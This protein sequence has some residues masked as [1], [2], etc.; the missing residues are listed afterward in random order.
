MTVTRLL[1]ALACTVA[2]LGGSPAAAQ[3]QA[4]GLWLL[5]HDDSVTAQ[6]SRVPAGFQ[7]FHL[8]RAGDDGDFQRITEVPVRP[9]R[10]PNR[11]LVLLGED[12]PVLQDRTRSATEPEL[13]RRLQSNPVVASLYSYL[14]PS[15][16]GVLGRRFTDAE[17][18]AGATYRYRAV[19]V[20]AAGQ[21]TSDVREAT[22]TVSD[23]LP[24]T[25]SGGGAEVG[26]N[27]VLLTWDY[28][29]YRGD[30]Q[31]FTVGFHVY[32][33][34]AGSDLFVRRTRSPVTRDDT[35]DPSWE[36][37][38]VV[39]G[40]GYS[41]RVRAVDLLG[42]EGAPSAA[43]QVTPADP[44]PPAAPGSVRTFP[45]EG[46][47]RVAW[48]VSPE[49]DVVGYRVERAAGLD[50]SW[51]TLNARL[52]EAQEPIWDDSTATGGVQ[53]FY[54]VVAVD[55]AGRESR[56]SNP[57]A[58]TAFDNRPPAAPG[59]LAAEVTDRVASLSWT[60]PG[61]EDVV[62]YHV[63]RGE[64]EDVMVRLTPE[65]VT[66]T[67]FRDAGPDG[68]GLNPGGR[69]RLRV[70]ALDALANE[71]EPAV[72]SVAVPDDEAPAA[73]SSLDVANPTGREA[74]VRWN[75]SPSLDVAAYVLTRARV[76]GPGSAEG[77]VPGAGVP[78]RADTV[79]AGDRF[80]LRQGDLVPGD[81]YR[82]SVV[83][84]DSAG[85]VSPPARVDFVFRDGTPPPAPA[86]L[87]AR[88]S[89]EG[90]VVIWERVV[91]DDLAGYRI[92]RSDL[93]TGRFEPVSGLLDTGGQ[94]RFVDPGGQAGA[95]YRVE[96]EDTSGNAAASAPTRAGGG[97]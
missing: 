64:G 9:I 50:Q 32:R 27:R 96:A 60:A 93:P 78:A 19:L 83:A 94:L 65:P 72:L 30:P 38:D 59:D 47:V 53:L 66:G 97:S 10:D 36:D 46:M 76:S 92:L 79:A 91:A 43:V 5:A 6:L 57:V 75:A 11:F 77:T 7:G 45:G 3:V 67:T 44:D 69:Y 22:V 33:A 24:G 84:V 29:D 52:V 56:P 88:D 2:F 39:N 68:A 74:R 18:E 63:Y 82:F 73:P 15:V 34:D 25:P 42:R 40:A 51:D 17:V 49:T 35:A 23:V 13:V 21:E 55:A 70:T 89:A 81:S 86:F 16:A 58:A 1:A 61:D 26:D 41:Y 14:F 28:P 4:P 80:L 8:Y 87:Q 62:G 12:G 54:R 85:N 37:L 71:S 20:D 48:L 90:V 95:W 31:D